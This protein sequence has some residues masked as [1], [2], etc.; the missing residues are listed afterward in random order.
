MKKLK[1]RQLKA[2][3][4]NA[5]KRRR[6]GVLVAAAA[7]FTVLVAS[8]F[9]SPS[10]HKVESI[11]QDARQEQD[12]QKTP[13]EQRSE[14]RLKFFSGL[15]KQRAW[16]L[17]AIINAGLNYSPLLSELKNEYPYKSLDCFVPRTE[18]TDIS[19]DLD[20]EGFFEQSMAIF[21][22]RMDELRGLKEE[23]NT[24]ALI[25]IINFLDSLNIEWMDNGHRRDLLGEYLSMYAEEG[26]AANQECRSRIAHTCGCLLS[27]RIHLLELVEADP[28]TV[29]A[30]LPQLSE[31]QQ[32]IFLHDIPWLLIDDPDTS[33][34]NHSG[35]DQF[36]SIYL[37]LP[38]SAI[39]KVEESLTDLVAFWVECGETRKAVSLLDSLYGRSAP[40]MRT[41][42]VK[43]TLGTVAKRTADII[44]SVLDETEAFIEENR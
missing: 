36:E 7:A 16:S 3:Q 41:L 19:L 15:A 2:Q 9:L 1:K 34:F 8:H 43:V 32:D 14:K 20:S 37:N 29:A 44:S 11:R 6:T 4:E 12:Q 33:D 38:D 13:E 5:K 18:K 42:R 24:E 25:S 22:R 28:S 31:R 35:L 40:Q 21:E 26:I 30:I 27:A 10:T 39:C 23:R 17:M